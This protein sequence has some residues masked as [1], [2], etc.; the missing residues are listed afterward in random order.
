MKM[1]KNFS[2]EIKIAPRNEND[3]ERPS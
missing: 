3:R 1:G 2:A